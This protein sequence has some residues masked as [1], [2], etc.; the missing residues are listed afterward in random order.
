MSTV[1]KYEVNTS[2]ADGSGRLA[3]KCFLEVIFMVS[4]L[5]IGSVTFVLFTIAFRMDYRFLKVM[6]DEGICPLVQ[7]FLVDD[8]MAI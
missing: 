8:D 5:E 7:E 1:D 6:G 3:V 2:G 4:G